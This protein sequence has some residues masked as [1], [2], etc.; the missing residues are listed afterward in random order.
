MNI[1][2]FIHLYLTIHLLMIAMSTAEQQIREKYVL[3]IDCG[4]ESARVGL[5]SSSDGKLVSTSSCPYRTTFP[6]SGW[7]EQDPEEWWSSLGTASRSAVEQLTASL[8]DD[9]FE[10]VAIGMDTTGG[11]IVIVA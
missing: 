8:G 9:A 4:T 1:Y 3:A 11:W 7:A 10:I 5:F 2:I 6:R